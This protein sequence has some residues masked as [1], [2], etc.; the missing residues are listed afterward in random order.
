[1]RACAHVY[2]SNISE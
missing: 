1:V 2:I